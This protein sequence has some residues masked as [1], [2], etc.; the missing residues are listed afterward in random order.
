M[1]VGQSVLVSVRVCFRFQKAFA[2]SVHYQ[3]R[4][5]PRLD[6]FRGVDAGHP[7]LPSA[8]AAARRQFR[9]TER[10]ACG[11][12]SLDCND[13]EECRRANRSVTRGY[14]DGVVCAQGWRMLGH[15]HAENDDDKKAIHCLEA[16]LD[17][18]S[19]N[20]SACVRVDL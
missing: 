13:V 17:R 12:G 7:G 6:P 14:D 16:S 15:C 11:G 19:Y 2:T 10:V 5:W 20:L 4:A 9:G 18:D 3:S 8:R 1:Q